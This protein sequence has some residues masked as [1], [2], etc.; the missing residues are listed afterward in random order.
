MKC[1]FPGPQRLLLYLFKQ[2]QLS[3]QLETVVNTVWVVS[4][5]TTTKASIHCKYVDLNTLPHLPSPI[6]LLSLP[7]I[8]P[9]LIFPVR[10]GLFTR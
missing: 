5:Y 8:F 6:P 7:L 10:Y 4:I 2:I 1:A 9:P 3:I